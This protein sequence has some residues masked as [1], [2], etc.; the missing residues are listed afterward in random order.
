MSNDYKII[1]NTYV[2]SV[3]ND[4][5]I[6]KCLLQKINTKSFKEPFKLRKS[7]KYVTKI[8]VSKKCCH[9]QRLN[10]V[11]TKKISAVKDEK[12][13]GKLSMLEELSQ[14][15]V[16][17]LIVRFELDKFFPV[18]LNAVFKCYDIVLKPTDFKSLESNPSVLNNV[19]TKG[20]VLGAVRIVNN[21]IF[22]FYKKG[23]SPQR[24]KFVIAYELAQCCLHAKE[25]AS[26][27]HNCYRLEL[28]SPLNKDDAAYLFASELMVPQSIIDKIYAT[29]KCPN[30]NGFVKEFDVPKDV[31]IN[32]LKRLNKEYTDG[33][34]SEMT[35]YLDELE[36]NNI[37]N[38]VRKSY[39][40]YNN[41]KVKK[42]KLD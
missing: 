9:K 42:L 34:L 16:E 11:S 20:S 8:V 27:G 26:S 29:V 30:I 23:D 5:K 31:A 24:Q 21:Q 33:Y 15:S 12:T 14:T 10:D 35:P 39:N 36:I 17:D 28:E 6:V 7:T 32:R 38:S 3:N 25:I 18:D 37:A 19:Y 2:I 40:R 1:N 13:N 22:I 41:T 4:G